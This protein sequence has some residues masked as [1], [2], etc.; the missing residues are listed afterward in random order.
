M[1]VVKEW[2]DQMEAC[3]VAFIFQTL[4]FHQLIWRRQGILLALFCVI[5]FRLYYLMTWRRY[6]NGQTTNMLTWALLIFGK[7]DRKGLGDWIEETVNAWVRKPLKEVPYC[8][9]I[10]ADKATFTKAFFDPVELSKLRQVS[11]IPFFGKVLEY[12]VTV[13]LQG[14]LDF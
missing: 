11:N 3:S 2:C 4:A 14:S 10:S 8:I 12:K 5:L 7:Q 1:C 13:H 6:F 9:E